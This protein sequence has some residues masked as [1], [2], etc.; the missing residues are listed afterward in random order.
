MHRCG[1]VY[2]KAGRVNRKAKES[3]RGREIPS[4]RLLQDIR[5]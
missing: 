1:P 2:R 4:E 3:R 5:D